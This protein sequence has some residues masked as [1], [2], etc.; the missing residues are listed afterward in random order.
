MYRFNSM[1]C[2]SGLVSFLTVY[3]R[4]SSSPPHFPFLLVRLSVH[5]RV[6]QRS[7]SP[8]IPPC[9]RVLS[10]SVVTNTIELSLWRRPR[11]EVG[12]FARREMRRL[13]FPQDTLQAHARNYRNSSI[14]GGWN[15][16]GSCTRRET[17]CSQEQRAFQ[18]TTVQ[19]R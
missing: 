13:P 12:L 4:I 11:L 3:P 9:V 6:S 2:L 15:G 17:P 16:H 18:T 10:V 1:T 14:A 8:W 5:F 19:S 7:V